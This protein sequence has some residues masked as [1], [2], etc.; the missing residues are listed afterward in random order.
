MK[1]KLT[2]KQKLLLTLLTL[3]VVSLF[4][5]DPVELLPQ[6]LI[7]PLVA[8]SADFL[9]N[10]RKG[11]NYFPDAAVISGLIIALVLAPLASPVAVICASILAIA[12]KHL[13]RLGGRH[14]FNPAAFGIIASSYFFD[15]SHGW[16]GDVV[17]VL[18]LISLG[19]LIIFVYR[20]RRY[21]QVGSHLAGLL[22]GALVFSF[23]KS[24]DPFLLF[25][26]SISPFFIGVML[27]EPQT[28]PA[29]KYGQALFGF[30]TGLLS[31][32]VSIFGGVY[33]LPF[34]LLISNL[35]V[36][37]LNKFTRPTQSAVPAKV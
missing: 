33:P 23:V 13:V 21:W 19:S 35:F 31:F 30:L 1:L 5:F 36:P 12:S 18:F 29:Y 27:M 3:S 37:L 15:L 22:I 4:I 9:I 8:G 16:L 10:W 11:K 7:A 25:R 14:I 2:L 34:A 32:G 20:M 17:P 26:S 6:L 28:S 24:G